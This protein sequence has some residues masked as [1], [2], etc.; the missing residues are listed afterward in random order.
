M[1]YLDIIKIK[2][3]IKSDS[4]YIFNE[5][6]FLDNIVKLRN[7][8]NKYYCKY[9]FAYSFKTN[10]CPRIV[11]AV[12]K[13][14][15]LAE[16]VSD[17]EYEVA[18][19]SGFERKNIIY[20]GPVKFI[21][22]CIELLNG[23]GTVIID[24]E[25]ELDDLIAVKPQQ[26]NWNVGIRCNLDM[27]TDRIS[28]FGFDVSSKNFQ[29]VLSKIQDKFNVKTI[30]CHLSG[31]RGLRYWKKRAE[32]LISIAKSLRKLPE[33]IDLGSGMFGEMEET[34]RAQFDVGIPSFDEYARCI[35]SIFSDAFKDIDYEN[36]PVIFTEPGTTIV[37]NTISFCCP[38]TSMKNIRGKNFVEVKGSIHNIG[39]EVAVHK[40]LPFSLIPCGDNSARRLVSNADIV[41][42]TCLEYDSL[43]RGYTGEIAL[44]DYFEFRNIGC[45]SNVLKPPF[46]F[47]NFPMIC[48]DN[49]RAE[50][51]KHM[52]SNEDLYRTYVF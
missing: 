36:K 43:Q 39:A 50:V 22:T 32:K 28:R 5:K 2:E 48:Y 51:I 45:Y 47:P 1:N 13:A 31:Y 38:V 26:S 11:S 33:I 17:F 46:I 35:G 18:I 29:D 9:N 49:G 40:N 16:I 8:F 4:F 15:G 34:F 23:G 37:A 14:G 41:G 12:N 24:N 44:G 21:S 42:Y 3:Q 7:A 10:Y 19:K 6:A 25:Q 30:H 52:E 20:N 27:D